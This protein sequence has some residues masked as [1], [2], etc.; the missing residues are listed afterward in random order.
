MGR[1]FTEPEASK[2]WAISK[3]TLSCL[4]LCGQAAGSFHTGFSTGPVQLGFMFPC[5][6]AR[7]P[8]LE[9]TQLPQLAWARNKLAVGHVIVRASSGCFHVSGLVPGPQIILDV[10][11]KEVSQSSA[12]RLYFTPHFPMHFL[13]T[14]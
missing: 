6:L 7:G 4:A 13:A 9:Q 2:P 10:D 12:M 1:I 5:G 11:I 8:C 14:F 3:E